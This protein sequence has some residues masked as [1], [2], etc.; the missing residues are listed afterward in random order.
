MS[1]QS[2]QATEALAREAE[3]RQLRALLAEQDARHE[4][5]AEQDRLRTQQILDQYRQQD[6]RDRLETEAAAID[7]YKA[8]VRAQAVSTV[9]PALLDF[10]DGASREAIDRSAALARA[11]TAEIRAAQTPARLSAEPR[12]DA[13]TGRFAPSA[14]Q[15]P[16]AEIDPSISLADYAAMRSELGIAERGI[17]HLGRA[18]GREKQEFLG[19]ELADG[20]GFADW[21]DYTQ[22]QRVFE[23]QLDTKRAVPPGYV[24]Q[25]A[26]QSDG[27]R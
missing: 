27:W 4:A 5:L 19:H 24:R 10:I 23:S 13:Q 7:T 20:P 14:P 17:E 26:K 21:R 22:N 2:R 11:K 12:R 1:K 8:E 3:Q 6:A 18:P 9:A 25:A 15:Q 16:A